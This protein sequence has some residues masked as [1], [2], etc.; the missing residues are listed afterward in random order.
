[1]M[2]Y[3][4][5]PGSRCRPALLA[6]VLVLGFSSVGQTQDG[7]TEGALRPAEATAD[8]TTPTALSM[9]LP[10][11]T[12]A[13]RA[14]WALRDTTGPLQVGFGRE[15]PVAYQADL[16][17]RLEWVTR[18]DGTLVSAVRVTSPGAWA[19]RVA[20][21]AIL[22]PDATL[23][24]FNPADPAQYFEPVTQ[25]DFTAQDTGSAEDLELPDLPVWSPVI[26]GETVGM[27][28]SL[29]SS[30][31]LSTFSLYV[32]QVSHLV[33]HPVSSV[34][35]YQR[36]RLVDIGRA[37]CE[38]IDIQCVAPVDCADLPMALQARCEAAQEARAATAKMIFTTEDGYTA[39]CT[40]T[41][42]KDDAGGSVIPY[43]LTAHHCIE[44]QS[45]A[46]TLV[47][48]WDFERTI[49]RASDSESGSET[50]E[51]DDPT[52]LTQ[53]TGGADLLATHPESDSSL[54]RLRRPPPA[55]DEEERE[56]VSW[57]ETPLTHPT[58]VYGVHHPAA[59][60]KKYSAGLTV[61]FRD[62]YLGAELQ[63]VRTVEVRWSQGTVEPGSSGSGLFDAYGQL[64]GVLSGSPAGM[65]CGA[66]VVYGRFD[67]FF[68]LIRH[69][70]DPDGDM[71]G[72]TR[73]AA[74]GMGSASSTPRSLEYG[75][76]IDYFRVEVTQAG[77]LTVET[78]GS[79]DTV[80]QLRGTDGQWLSNDDDGSSGLNFR[81]V[82][83]VSAGT[84]YVRVSGFEN[85]TGPYTLVVRF[86]GTGTP[87]EDHAGTPEQ[88][89]SV[90]LNSSTSGVL[91]DGG[92]IDY[93]R[94]E[95]TQAG[96]LTVETTGNTDTAGQLRGAGG[97]R[98][99]QDDDGGSR[100]NFRLA[101]QVTAGT[102]YIRVSGFG[103]ASGAYVLSVRF[104]P[105]L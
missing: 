47:T 97:Q 10:A 77:T 23:R 36:Q 14:E 30:Q 1:M 6:F 75:G 45:V 85:A 55:L 5:I 82:W 61:D 34:P 63:E 25:Q 28:I 62:I 37:S 22:G 91:E 56:Y 93:F 104:A 49:K 67:R 83:Q 20:V 21:S 87:G 89:S 94:V 53:L 102:Y 17:S 76:D 54:L 50:C 60:L 88:A 13:E 35:R 80:G 99:S 52:T 66:S 64:R 31:A 65:E 15:I 48:Y 8:A 11:V 78:T 38:H 92:D 57:D 96:T 39:A 105:A 73:E 32:D 59:D 18:S 71:D 74:T 3:Y 70:L 41:L 86:A 103:D 95:V 16:A 84:Y 68:P 46:R 72:N 101:R 79:T 7:R 19:L 9:T 40:G 44:T 42:L 33:S 81:L 69:H 4:R 27:E 58:E 26:A 90:A 100:L 98:L 2:R 24:F 43:F 29:P 12:D 51:G